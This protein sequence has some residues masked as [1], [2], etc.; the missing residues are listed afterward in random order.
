[1]VRGDLNII[2]T[3]HRDILGHSEIRISQGPNR[4]NRCDIV[5]G[6]NRSE[7]PAVLQQ[8]LNDWVSRFRRGQVSL[9]LDCQLRTNFNPQLFGYRDQTE[10]S[11]IRVRAEGFPT[12]ALSVTSEKVPSSLCS[13]IARSGASLPLSAGN[14]EPFNK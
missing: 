5:E 6:Y 12:P 4:A 1:M 9:Q 7:H 2:E 13:S 14:V 3:D 10:P 8:F 11:I